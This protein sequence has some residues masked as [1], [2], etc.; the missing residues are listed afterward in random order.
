MAL[1]AE[2]QH[3]LES[4]AALRREDHEFRAGPEPQFHNH[5]ESRN[6]RYQPGASGPEKNKASLAPIAADLIP[7]IGKYGQNLP[8]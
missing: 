8:T 6:P 7:A 1:G 3:Y 4:L 2:H 5:A